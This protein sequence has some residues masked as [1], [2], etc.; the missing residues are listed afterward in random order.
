MQEILFTDYLSFKKNETEKYNDVWIFPV[1]SPSD[2]FLLNNILCDLAEQFPGVKMNLIE[3]ANSGLFFKNHPA[4]N[5]VGDPKTNSPV[6]KTD[7]WTRKEFLNNELD[8][9][10]TLA[11]MFGI[12][13]PA[14]YK[15]FF[16]ED[17]FKKMSVIPFEKD[18]PF[19]DKNILVAPFA[20]N[21]RL[22]Y[23]P[24]RWHMLV[25]NLINDNCFVIQAGTFQDVHIKGCYS[26]L[27]LLNPFQIFNLLNKV[28][29]VITVDNYIAN[30]ANY[31]K[32]DILIIKG[33]TQHRN[34]TKSNKIHIF[35]GVIYDDDECRECVKSDF[36]APLKDCKFMIKKCTNQIPVKVISDKVNQIL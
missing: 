19:K 34:L 3:R 24:M 13:R 30:F 35:N 21:I 27:G 11:K 20:H 22:N 10:G 18:I 6:V 32:P 9:L 33:P 31:I 25:N 16:D 29:L 14:E 26:V 23:E 4:L 12:Q 2:Y 8:A 15:T 17:T 36:F 1:G 5:S 7:Y 28:D